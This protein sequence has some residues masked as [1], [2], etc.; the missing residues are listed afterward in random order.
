MTKLIFTP[1]EDGMDTIITLENENG[2][3][4]WTPQELQEKK[5]WI[6]FEGLMKRPQGRLEIVGLTKTPMEWDKWN[7][8]LYITSEG[9]D[10]LR[11]LSVRIYAGNPYLTK[12]TRGVEK[13]LCT[14]DN[15]CMRKLNNFKFL[16]GYKALKQGTIFDGENFSFGETSFS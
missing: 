3:Y 13:Y 5:Y 6:L 2:K 7:N 10:V 11:S 15:I 8:I 12:E 1:S 14:D 4:S 9:E 16:I